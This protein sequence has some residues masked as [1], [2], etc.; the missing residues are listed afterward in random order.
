MWPLRS[1]DA[2]GLFLAFQQSD[3]LQ[4]SYSVKSFSTS[5][6]SR[7][8]AWSQVTSLPFPQKRRQVIIFLFPFAS[9]AFPFCLPPFPF[10]FLLWCWLVS[11]LSFPFGRL[12]CHKMCVE[13]RTTSGL[14]HPLFLFEIGSLT[15]LQLSNRLGWPASE[16]QASPR[17]PSAEITEKYH[18]VQ[19]FFPDSK[20]ACEAVFA[21]PSTSFLCF[22]CLVKCGPV[23]L[24]A[25]G[26]WRKCAWLLQQVPLGEWMSFYS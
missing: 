20:D 14:V 5:A 3:I 18:H 6:S 8:A 4:M 16:P 22:S 21:Q 1:C 7:C 9:P 25:P 17:S 10:P 2:D 12:G 24:E 19:M 13:Q 15:G 23:W 26:T 11:W